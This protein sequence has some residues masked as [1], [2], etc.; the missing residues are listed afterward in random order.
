[1]CTL[2]FVVYSV[3]AKYYKPKNQDSDLI[4]S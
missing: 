4:V 3:F 2:N 1:M